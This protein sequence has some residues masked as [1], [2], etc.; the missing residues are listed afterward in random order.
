MR[1]G[2]FQ[3]LLKP[4]P[5]K[6]HVLMGF[7]THSQAL[8]THKPLHNPDISRNLTKGQW[9]VREI[10]I[11]PHN[12]T[13]A[14]LTR[15]PQN[16]GHSQSPQSLPVQAFDPH[17]DFAKPKSRIITSTSCLKLSDDFGS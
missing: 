17:A 11:Y 14:A 7:C 12:C 1:I 10:Y 3:E 15:G 4:T 6:P 9:S 8:M 16:T 5:H 13:T 2:L